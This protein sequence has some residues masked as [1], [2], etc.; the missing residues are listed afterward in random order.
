MRSIV[1][2]RNASSVPV[3]QPTSRPAGRWA[4]SAGVFNHHGGPCRRDGAG[5]EHRRRSIPSLWARRWTRSPRR[6]RR[7][8]PSPISAPSRSSGAGIAQWA[9]QAVRKS[10]SVTEKEALSLRVIRFDAR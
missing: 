4:A 2:A 7:T 5:H 10:V 3:A 8:T 6:R 1:K 9:E